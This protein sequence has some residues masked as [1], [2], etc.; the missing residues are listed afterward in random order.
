M[1]K[2]FAKLFSGYSNIR[3]NALDS[4]N[5]GQMLRYFSSAP[6]RSIDHANSDPE[7]IVTS[8]RKCLTNGGLAAASHNINA[9]RIVS[10]F[11]FSK[12]G[13]FDQNRKYH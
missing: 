7:D 3:R 10:N 4:V 9:D 5:V 12:F 6:Y 1:E 13:C 11:D 2:A 8:I